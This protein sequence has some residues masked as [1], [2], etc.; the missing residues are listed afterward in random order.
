MNQDVDVSSKFI[1]FV[2]TTRHNR[3]F[4]ELDVFPELEI[5][6]LD[7]PAHR[8]FAHLLNHTNQLA[9]GKEANMGMPL[10]VMLDCG[11]LSSAIVG[12]ALKREDVDEV[13]AT[14]LS[15]PQ[16]YHTLV[17]VSEYCACP[18]LEPGCVSGFSLQ[19]QLWGHR[20]GL[21][22]KAL[23]MLVYGAKKQVGVTQ[24]DNPSI[25]V[26]AKFGPMRVLLHRPSVHTHTYNSFVY[27]VQLP[28][29]RTL[30]RLAQGVYEDMSLEHLDGERFSFDPALELHHDRLRALLDEGKD[31]WIIA[32]GWRATARGCVLDMLLPHGSD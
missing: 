29:R 2:L 22:T 9:F 21:R 27:H 18:T 32:P 8:A 6:E 13:L 26:H 16:E 23:A 20:L 25:R 10:W 12:F 5:L 4:L 28:S 31:V 11:I 24:F 7:D 30:V 19:S 3:S 1:P 15:I 17:P 14:R